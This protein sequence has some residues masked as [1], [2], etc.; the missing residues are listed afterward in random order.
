M[1][2]GFIGAG[3]MAE[4]IIAALI[5]NTVAAAAEITACDKVLER[6]DV[7]RQ[8]Y[9]ITTTAALD[10]VMRTCEV[11]ILAVKPQDIDDVLRRIAPQV[12]K[13]HLL[14]SIAAGKTLA[15]LHDTLGGEVRLVRVMPNLALQVGAGMS[16]WC[17]G[18]AARV[19]DGETV[20][21]IL[22]SAGRVVELAEEHFDAVT[23]LSGSGPAFF[24]YVM[25]ALA[26]GGVALGLPVTAAR[27]L[28]AQTMLGAAKVLLETGQEPT[29][30]IQAVASPQGT[31]AAGLAVLEQSD[32]RGI[33]NRT[34]QAASKRSEELSQA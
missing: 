34:L 12:A 3:K 7:L 23:A 33:L 4:A 14:I 8:R 5:R 17:R 30:F 16:A 9:G 15:V 32:L 20:C 31:T 10:D 22:G 19:S 26:D 13:H 27:T 6:L 29:T 21:Q 24:A 2:I 18:P 11:V 25:Q 1:K 28:A